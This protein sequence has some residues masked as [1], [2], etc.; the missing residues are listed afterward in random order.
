MSIAE[1]I[2]N[3]LPKTEIE[4]F[5]QGARAIGWLEADVYDAT[6]KNAYYAKSQSSDAIMVHLEAEITRKDN[7]KVIH[8]ER[9]CV[10]TSLGETTSIVAG[11]EKPLR[12][13]RILDALSLLGAGK[14]FKALQ[15]TVKEKLLTIG[16][17]PEA[18]YEVITG[19]VGKK[20]QLG[21]SP[22]REVNYK[23][24]SRTVTKASIDVVFDVKGYTVVEHR[25]LKE[26]AELQPQ[27]INIWR[28]NNK[29]VVHDL[30]K[31]ANSKTNKAGKAYSG[32]AQATNNAEPAKTVDVF[33]F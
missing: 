14:S 28:E 20:V 7:T 29:G 4:H 2:L 15:S 12:A 23:D 33:D 9:L 32:S 24:S 5:D 27:Y 19:L 21:M 16:N 17:R 3:K 25:L 13:Y 10:V 8:F 18:R 6:I 26:D 11:V 1:Q 22:K 30:T 31:S